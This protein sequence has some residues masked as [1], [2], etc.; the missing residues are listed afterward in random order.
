M[1]NTYTLIASSTVGAG[2]A[3]S[4]DFTSIPST[5]TDL[6]L[7]VSGRSSGGFNSNTVDSAQITLYNTSTSGTVTERWIYGQGSSAVSDTTASRGIFLTGSANTTSTFGN[8]QMYLPN[9]AGSQ[10]KSYS[11]DGVSEN[12]ATLSYVG[13]GAGLTTLTSAIN[14][15]TIAPESGANFV[16]YSTAYLYGIKNS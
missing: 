10:Q 6:C 9:Y 3:A 7:V 1:A 5:Y 13:L 8:G 12:N 4:I 14:K 2:G 16:Q 15:I 11:I